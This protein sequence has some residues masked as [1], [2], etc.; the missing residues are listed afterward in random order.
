MR[1][2]S[3]LILPA[4]LGLLALATPIVSLLFEYGRFTT[5]DTDAT[6]LVLRVYLLGLPFAAIAQML[7]FASYARK[8]TLRPALVGVI[9][10][11]VYL[12]VAF[13]LIEPLGLLS[14]MVADAVKLVVHTLLMLWLLRVK[15]GGLKGLGT[16]PTLLKATVAATLMGGA[17]LGIVQ[18]LADTLPLV[19]FINKVGIVL[20]GGL[21]GVVVYGLL[22]LLLNI[23]EIKTLPQLLLKRKAG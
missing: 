12:I 22:A 13:L 17:T 11:V 16:L 19:S 8:D 7:V 5:A 3:V 14:L 4:T 15:I 10:M 23:E 21:T 20:A 1:L 9:S 6:A 18:L 2:V